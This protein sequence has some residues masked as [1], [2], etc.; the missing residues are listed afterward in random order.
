LQSAFIQTTRDADGK[1]LETAS[2]SLSLQRPGRFYLRYQD[3]YA[4]EIISDG[5]TLWIYDQDLQQV[6]VDNIYVAMTQTPMAILSG[7][8]DLAAHFTLTESR[9]KES[10]QWFKLVPK[11]EDPQY[12]SI[13]IH[14]DAGSLTM[15]L[16]D[17]LG[18][19]TRIDL[20][21]ITYD[22]S[23]TI[24]YIFETPPGVDVMDNRQ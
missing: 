2:G 19:T 12:E 23:D 5:S 13:H 4:Q 22:P 20:T 14:I 6:I 24:Q 10:S 15:I 16:A 8:A 7:N 17:H 11:T 18:Q 21:D 9:H 3:P 1:I